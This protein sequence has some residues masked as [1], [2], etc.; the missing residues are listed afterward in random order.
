[1]RIEFDEG[2]LVLRDAPEGYLT[3][4]GTT[5]LTSTALKPIATVH[6]VNGPGTGIRATNR[7]PS[8]MDSLPPLRTRRESIPTLR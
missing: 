5:V 6:S 3:L 8:K 7:R 4:S 1:M 2:T